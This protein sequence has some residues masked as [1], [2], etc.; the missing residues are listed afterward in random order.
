LDNRR[1]KDIRY[2]DMFGAL[3]D[4]HTE[5]VGKPEELVPST[6]GS[7]QLGKTAVFNLIVNPIDFNPGVAA[8]PASYSRWFG[9]QKMRELLPADWFQYMDKEW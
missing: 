6:G 3:K 5:R 8:V 2:H 4:V 9:T 7:V 1:Q